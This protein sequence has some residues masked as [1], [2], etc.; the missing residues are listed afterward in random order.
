MPFIFCTHKKIVTLAIFI[1]ELY[2]SS[3]IN[4]KKYQYIKVIEIEVLQ[5]THYSKQ[6]TII[7]FDVIAKYFLDAMF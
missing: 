6:F 4:K 3:F 5:F 7:I 1:A 2:T